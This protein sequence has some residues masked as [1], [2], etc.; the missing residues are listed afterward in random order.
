MN[1]F[2]KT[3]CRAYS[4]KLYVPPHASILEIQG[5]YFFTRYYVSRD[6]KTSP[7]TWQKHKAYNWSFYG[8]V[9]EGGLILKLKHR[10]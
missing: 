7:F 3:I 6:V 1:W 9:A 2:F 8:D 5:K 10:F 4:L